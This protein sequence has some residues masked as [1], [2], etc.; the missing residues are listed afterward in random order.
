[1]LSS[2]GRKP[3]IM[4]SSLGGIPEA[5]FMLSNRGRNQ[6]ITVVKV[7]VCYEEFLDSD[8]IGCHGWISLP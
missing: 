7:R 2:L 8:M 3:Y 6:E 5:L 1:M 4:L